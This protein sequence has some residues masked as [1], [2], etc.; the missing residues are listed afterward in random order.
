L[1][2]I[3]FLVV[4]SILVIVHEFGHFILAV[5]NGVLVKR[6]SIGFGPKL[7]GVKKNGTEFCV[8]LI[9]LGGYVK[10][11]GEEPSEHTKG[12]ENEYLSKPVGK[13]AQIIVAGALLN[14][15]LAF[16]LFTFVFMVGNPTATSKVGRVIDG[17][18][19]ASHNI[20]QDDRI[21]AIDGKQIQY[22]E[23]L[24]EIIHKRLEG[25]VTLTIKR[26][27][28]TFN[29]TL[30]PSVRE[31]KNIFGKTIKIAQIG[32]APS[33]EIII[34][35]HNPVEALVLGGQRLWFF[36]ATTYKGLWA[37]ITGSMPVKESMTGPI[38]IFFLTKETAKLG[39]IY[40][41]HFM[42][43]LSAALA[44]FNLLPFPVL[45]GGHLIFLGIEKVRKKPVSVKVQ[46]K[47]TQVAI[48]LLI[49]L[50][51]FVSYGDITKF[52]IKEKILGMFK[53]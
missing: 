45:D 51:L 48:V 12:E 14:Y 21:I 41:V 8:C 5:K 49:A 52:G 20:K 15:L 3:I 6:F 18:P 25:S 34:V 26:G 32:I 46:E 38:G 4:L 16:L 24:T 1:S 28:R 43:L 22:W 27:D 47:I 9:P 33:T 37:M 53:K 40:L 39:F 10:M 7:F 31:I 30:E 42:A 29:T 19:A 50:M 36:T 44:I 11:A 17:F 23:E 2:V 13:R 35:K